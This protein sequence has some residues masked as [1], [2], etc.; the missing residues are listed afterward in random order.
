MD[1]LQIAG[2]SIGFRRCGLSAG[3]TNTFTTTLDYHYTI[4]GQ[5]YSAAALSNYAGPA[6][7][8]NTGAAFIP[9]GP[10]KA[11]VFLFVIDG[12]GTFAAATRVAQGTIVD[13][14]GTADAANASY[15]GRLPEFPAV[16]DNTCVYGWCVV[17]VGASGSPW[18]FGT[19][20]NS[21]V[22]NTT[23]TFTPGAC[24]PERP[25]G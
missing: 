25:R 2:S 10:N 22:A 1:Q 6:V 13:L 12:S 14:D 19:S 15:V 20:N 8:A 24:L 3:T 16:P 9:V 23:V 21:G 7:D 18:T 4:E 11:C 5:T 17:K